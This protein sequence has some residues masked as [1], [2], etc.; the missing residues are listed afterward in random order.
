[1]KPNFPTNANNIRNSIASV[2]A[3]MNSGPVVHESFERN[4]SGPHSDNPTSRDLADAFM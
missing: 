1:M 3:G 2:H 4:G